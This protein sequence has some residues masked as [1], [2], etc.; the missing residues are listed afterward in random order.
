[1]T[2]ILGQKM[3]RVSDGARGTVVLRDGVP[4]IL[5]HLMADEF[6]APTREQWVAEELPVAPLH[7]EEIER[8]AGTADQVLYC[9][10]THTP[11]RFWEAGPAEPHDRGL[12]EVIKR[13]LRG[14]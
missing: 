4:R 11:W 1:M 3:V 6:L 9:L 12:V 7:E 8:V 14:E 10:R 2:L 5:F 13:Y